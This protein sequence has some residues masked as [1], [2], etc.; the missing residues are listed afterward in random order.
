MRLKSEKLTHFRVY[1]A[2]TVIPIDEVMTGIVGRNQ[3]GKSTIL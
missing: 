3:Y 1:R 2:S